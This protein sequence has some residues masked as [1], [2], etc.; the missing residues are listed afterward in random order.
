M[1]DFMKQP[2]STQC[3]QFLTDNHY[4]VGATVAKRGVEFAVY[5][6]VDLDVGEHE[7][8]RG[9]VYSERGDGVLF[10]VEAQDGRKYTHCKSESLRHA[11]GA[12][13]STNKK[14][15]LSTS[16]SLDAGIETPA[17]KAGKRSL[18]AALAELPA[19]RK[20]RFTIGSDKQ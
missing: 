16:K 20:Q 17:R 7:L 12:F 10:S 13:V 11:T 15:V 2:M 9:R 5:G 18:E 4:K 8:V 14:E 3:L 6:V 19:P 1:V